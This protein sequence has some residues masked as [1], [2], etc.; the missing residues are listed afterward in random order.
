MWKVSSINT[1]NIDGA[2]TTA[3]PAAS[4]ILRVFF[5]YTGDKAIPREQIKEKNKTQRTTSLGPASS[6]SSARLNIR[7]IRF[8]MGG[9]YAIAYRLA[10]R[11]SL[12]I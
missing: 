5:F 4:R 12:S 2:V 7:A 10:G 3:M 1:S 6:Q 11:V 9:G 8:S